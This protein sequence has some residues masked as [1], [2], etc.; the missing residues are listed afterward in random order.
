MPFD[1]EAPPA[2][3]IR[4]SARCHV[5]GGPC[6][7]QPPATYSADPETQSRHYRCGDCGEQWFTGSTFAL[8][9]E[10]LGLVP[11]SSFEVEVEPG[12]AVPPELIGGLRGTVTTRAPGG[13]PRESMP[14]PKLEPGDGVTLQLLDLG[15][16]EFGGAGVPSR[17]IEEVTLDG[18]Y[19]DSLAGKLVDQARAV[20]W[21]DPNAAVAEL[22]RRGK[23]ETVIRTTLKSMG[24]VCDDWD[25]SVIRVDPRKREPARAICHPLGAL[26]PAPSP[27]CAACGLPSDPQ[28]RVP[29]SGDDLVPDGEECDWEPR[30]ACRTCYDRHERVRVAVPVKGWRQ[31]I[32]FDAT[33][34]ILMRAW[35]VLFAELREL[36]AAQPDHREVEQAHRRLEEIAGVRPQKDDR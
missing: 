8:E 14:I 31:S 9:V 32:R 26:L 11:V 29:I 33:A 22:R 24:I 5:C 2:S 28:L 27:P 17:P 25:G 23:S 19:W 20:D 16:H 35:Q 30:P 10:G 21:G 34:A 3:G 13:E 7:E 36:E 15:N 18:P 4:S 12:L 6:A 1:P